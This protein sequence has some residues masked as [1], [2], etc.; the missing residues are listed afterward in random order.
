[1]ACQHP[2]NEF[3]DCDDTLCSSASTCL[4]VPQRAST[5]LNV[6]QRASTCLNVPQR[7]ST[8]LN[9]PQRASTCLNVP[10][11]AST[12][13]NVPQRASTCLNVPQRASTCLNVPQRASTCLNVPQRASTCLNVPQRASTCLN[14]PQRASTCLMIS[15]FCPGQCRTCPQLPPSAPRGLAN[16]ALPA[17]VSKLSNFTPAVRL[18]R[19]IESPSLETASNRECNMDIPSQQPQAATQTSHSRDMY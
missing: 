5:C 13:L 7:A 4:N 18:V 9:V 15:C 1:M 10:Q 16:S 12:C 6:P 11:R 3:S 19:A 2:I 17:R 14:V 8:C